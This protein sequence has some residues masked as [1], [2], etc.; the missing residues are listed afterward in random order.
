MIYG[1]KVCEKHGEALI[2]LN[3]EVVDLVT[4]ALTELWIVNFF[5]VGALYS[6]SPS[7]Q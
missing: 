2:K 3:I 6:D 7:L 5:P 1:E 4:S